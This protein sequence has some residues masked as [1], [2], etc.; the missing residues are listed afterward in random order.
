MFI[1]IHFHSDSRTWSCLYSF[2]DNMKVFQMEAMLSGYNILM[3]KVDDNTKLY[4]GT[5]D[6]KD[7]FQSVF[8]MYGHKI[9]ITIE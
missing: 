7:W 4:S 3:E 1:D 9:N 6:S 8:R 5:F 2:T